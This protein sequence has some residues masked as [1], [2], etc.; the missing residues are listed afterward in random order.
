MKELKEISGQLTRRLE[1]DKTKPEVASL[2]DLLTS[3]NSMPDLLTFA[4]ALIS[5][6]EGGILSTLKSQSKKF[7]TA[8]FLACNQPTSDMHN[9]DTLKFIKLINSTL[10]QC[11]QV[12]N[13]TT[14][15]APFRKQLR[16][17]VGE[18][19]ALFNSLYLMRRHNLE[20]GDKSACIIKLNNLPKFDEAQLEAAIAD[21]KK[22]E[23][24]LKSYHFNFVYDPQQQ[25]NYIQFIATKDVIGKVKIECAKLA[26]D[27][28]QSKYGLMHV[29]ITD[30][31][32]KFNKNEPSND[33]QKHEEWYLKI[34][35]RLAT[36][37]KNLG[38]AIEQYSKTTFKSEVNGLILDALTTLQGTVDD[39]LVLKKK[40]EDLHFETLPD[41]VL[42]SEFKFK[43]V[44]DAVMDCK[45]QCDDAFEKVVKHKHPARD[46]FDIFL[47]SKD[48]KTRD[49]E[50]T[51]SK[52]IARMLSLPH[53]PAAAAISSATTTTVTSTSKTS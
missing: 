3:L 22:Y 17:K 45:A 37:E 25:K 14:I 30:I 13:H 24:Q 48:D 2:L 1:K 10:D 34:C 39:I 47:T 50:A 18:G 46:L 40:I 44:F 43:I 6:K 21:F 31:E 52:G 20:Q 9:D 19:K 41:P 23:G 29:E 38:L 5:N 26:G 42:F 16:A 51:I 15:L 36:F 27:D 33:Y 49:V 28:K 53:A 4:K 7:R 11:A 32:Q 8:L 35:K 12:V